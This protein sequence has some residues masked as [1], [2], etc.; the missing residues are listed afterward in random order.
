MLQLSGV[1]ADAVLGH[2]SE[3]FQTHTAPVVYF[4]GDDLSERE[5]LRNAIGQRGWRLETISSVGASVAEAGD[6]VP[7]C[8][9]LDGYLLDHLPARERARVPVICLA[10]RADVGLTVRAMRGGALDVLPKPVRIGALVEVVRHAL[11]LSATCLLQWAEEQGLQAR[12]A[13]LSCRERQVMELVVAGRM[14]KQIGGDLGISEVTVKAHRAQVMRKM[15]APSLADLVK[16]AARLPPA[17]V[18]AA[19]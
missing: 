9:V 12:H 15:M 11:G 2:I 7:R 17:P 14:N 13:S 8:L 16:M 1:S 5:R 3:Q 4:V 10:G 6:M 18:C 19:N